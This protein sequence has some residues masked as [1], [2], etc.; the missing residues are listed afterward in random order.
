LRSA[1]L[2]S[3]VAVD[4]G[5]ATMNSVLASASVSPLRSVRAPPM[6]CQ[7]PLRPG[8]EYTGIPAM[9]SASRS[10]RAV[11]TDTSSSVASSVAVTRPRACNTSSMATSRSARMWPIFA[12]NLVTT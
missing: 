12:L 3:G 8:C 9:A 4:A 5:P 6:S 11:L 10:R 7:P 1:A 2:A